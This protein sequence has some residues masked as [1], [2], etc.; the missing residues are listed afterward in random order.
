MEIVRK[1]PKYGIAEGMKKNMRIIFCLPGNKFSGKFLQSWTRLLIWCMQSGID[2]DIL[3]M[4]A[5][6]IYHVRECFLTM[7]V[8][9]A[10]NKIKPFGGKDYDYAF[11]ID[12]DQ[13]FSPEQ[14]KRLLLH[15]CDF[16][17]GAIR[18]VNS[19]EMAFGWIDPELLDKT[20]DLKRMSVQECEKQKD[21]IEV[22]FMG[23]AFTLVKKGVFESL[24]FPYFNPV[25]Y[26]AVV[27]G[28]Y[29]F[30]GED[31]SICYRLREKGFK[32]YVD[33]TVRVG[34]EKETVS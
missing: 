19:N 27:P 7:T 15:D 18:V 29:G 23:L 12:S 1:L 34:H 14:L 4:H 2:A 26:G 13:V 25:G 20:S 16:V 5:S 17:G 11:W 33:P 6:N 8:C 22:D 3:Q 24:D 10:T 30:M 9:A 21:L 32:I 31:L 28:K